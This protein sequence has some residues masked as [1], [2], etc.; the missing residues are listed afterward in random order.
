MIQQVVHRRSVVWWA[1]TVALNV[2]FWILAPIL[3]VI[4]GFV[5]IPY[6]TFVHYA[7]RNRRLTKR[8]TRRGISYYGAMIVRCG[9]PFVRVRFIDCDPGQKMPCVFVANHRSLSDGFLMA[10]LPIETVQVLNIW[11]AHMP[12]MGT[13]A[14]KGEY[15]KVR[16]MPFDEFL[17]AGSKLISVGCSV[18]AFPEGTRSGSRTMGPFHGSSFR[19][20]QRCGV[21]IVP[22]A[23]AGNERIPRKGSLLLHPGRITFTKLPAIQPEQYVGMSPYQLKNLARDRIRAHLDTIESGEG[24]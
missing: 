4:Y 21:S 10:Y 15:L 8:L 24:D 19:L 11:P 13:L 6:V 22:I 16:E 23:I 3:S 2:S 14:A 7:L 17:E 12:V 1:Q 18:I 9:W 20:A 5:A